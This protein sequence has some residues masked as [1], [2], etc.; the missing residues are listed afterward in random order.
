VPD[1]TLPYGSVI[2]ST[3]GNIDI[4]LGDD[5]LFVC[6]D[7][8]PDSLDSRSFGPIKTDQIVGK[9]VLRVFPLNKVD[10]F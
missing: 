3:Q 4:R 5:E 10:K 6:G 7:N 2:P 9:L 8:R 1:K